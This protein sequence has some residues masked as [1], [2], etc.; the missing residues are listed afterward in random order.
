VFHSF[1]SYVSV[2]G[3]CEKKLKSTRIFGVKQKHDPGLRHRYFTCLV[4]SKFAAHVKM[5]DTPAKY[6]RSLE[7]NVL[8]NMPK[9]DGWA[10]RRNMPY[11]MSASQHQPVLKG[12]LLFFS[13]VS[14]SKQ[15]LIQAVPQRMIDFK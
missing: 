2:K 4:N 8:R 10:V 5:I 12:K 3:R 14:N 1:P 6:D 11:K 9:N 7:K 15:V 13:I